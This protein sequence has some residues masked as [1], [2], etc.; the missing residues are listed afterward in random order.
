MKTLILLFVGLT[1]QAAFARGVNCRFLC[2]R[3]T[4]PTL[5]VPTGPDTTV[6]ILLPAEE[7]ST[8][9]VCSVGD[10]NRLVFRDP[11]APD[12]SLATVTIPPTTPSVIVVF[13]AS[14]ATTPAWQV[15]VI[16]D[17]PAKFPDGGV[18]V[19]NFQPQE[20]RFNIGEHKLMLKTGSIHAVAKPTQVD[21][22]NMAPIK[23]EFRKDD[24]W[25]TASESTQRFTEGLRYLMFCYLDPQSGRP[26]VATFQ[27]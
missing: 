3:G 26:R 15:L 16:D 24:Q 6:S 10:D 12:K 2:F 23:F 14:S 25:R 19:G 9:T 13:T 21:S 20:I 11:A 5:L 8:P 22:F 1:L 18:Y 7:I 4:P 27:D 17:S